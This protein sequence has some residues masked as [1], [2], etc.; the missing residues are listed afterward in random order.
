MWLFFTHVPLKWII[1]GDLAECCGRITQIL[2]I[3]NGNP[4]KMFFSQGN[5]FYY[6]F[7]SILSINPMDTGDGWEH[8]RGFAV[9]LQ[10]RFIWIWT[11]WVYQTLTVKKYVYLNIY[12]KHFGCWWPGA[13]ASAGTVMTKLQSCLHK[14]SIGG[15]IN[16][17]SFFNRIL[18]G[19]FEIPSIF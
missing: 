13:R 17:N 18:N 1:I 10:K 4:N 16:L 5:A 6:I 11:F 2:T 9:A 14:W 15:L 3:F 12:C 8:V 7:Y 19:I